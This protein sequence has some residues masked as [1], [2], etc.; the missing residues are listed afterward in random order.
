MRYKRFSGVNEDISSLCIG[1]WPMANAGYGPVRDEDSIDAIH[2]YV[3][4][5]VNVLDTAPDYGNG[6]SE[7]VVGK[8]L[9]EIPRDK[10][11]IA[12]KV[13][14]AFSTMRAVRTGARYARDGRYENVLYEC[15]Q[16]LR[17][18]GTDYIDFYFVHWPDLNTPFSETMEAMKTLIAQGKIRWVGLS[19]FQKDQVIECSNVCQITAI[20][21]PFSMAVQRDLELLKWAK[22]NRI[23]TFTYGSIGGGI[24]TGEFREEPV[25]ERRMD[26]RNYF[27][28]F[29]KEP[30]FSKVMKVVEVLDE[31]SKETGRPNVQV[32]INWQTQKDYISTALVGT[33]SRQEAL[34]NAAS[35][36][37]ELTPEQIGR[38]DRAVDEYIDFDGTDPSKPLKKN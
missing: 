6:Y 18:L 11:F 13:G 22:A 12:T 14:A 16:S 8:A 36:E 15:E 25:W 29:F 26:P 5:G 31:I 37:W 9:K 17:R 33:R 1:T 7:T 4:A 30:S 23:N 34:M 3:D 32:A 20:Q 27:Y 2:A 28:P 35:F 19:N 10:L 24:L 38:I 21:P